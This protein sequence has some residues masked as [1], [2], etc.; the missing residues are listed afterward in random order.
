MID[1]V[2]VWIGKKY[3]K[4]YV[5]NLYHGVKSHLTT[6]FRFNIITHESITEIPCRI[7]SPPVLD[8]NENSL[9]WYKMFMFSPECNFNKYV[10]YL[11]LD[12]IIIN[13][14]NKFTEYSLDKFCICQDF[15]RNFMPKY[16]VSNSSVMRFPP[17]KYHSLWETWISKK[18]HYIKRFRGDQ[19]FIT[20]WFE[21]PEYKLK[22]EWWPKEWAMSYK[23]EIEMGGKKNNGTDPNS[24]RSPNTPIEIPKDC[25]IVVCH[26]SPKPDKVH[27]KLF[28]HWHK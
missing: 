1:V 16:H 27:K 21:N 22:K 7:I 6:E 28:K 17:R 18:E 15:N 8:L 26:G 12:V 14:I 4:E 13:S 10:L 25:S 20:D 3:S 24:Y 23:W 19:D 2:C 5:L 9:W 11:D